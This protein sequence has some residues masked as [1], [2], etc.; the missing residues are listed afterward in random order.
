MK[1]DFENKWV[2]EKELLAV[3][4]SN[5]QGSEL[6]PIDLRGI[7][8]GSQKKRNILENFNFSYVDFSF[9]DFTECNF[10]NLTFSNCKFSNVNFSDLRQ[11]NC[12]YD[13]CIFEKSNFNNA[14]LGVNSNFS[15]CTFIQTTLKGKYFNF[16]QNNLF[17]Q[18]NFIDCDINS[19]WILSVTFKE[20]IFASKFS[21][22]RFS[23]TKE[24]ALSNKTE[25]KNYPATF[26][27]CNFEKSTFKDLEIMDGSI[28]EKTILPNQKSERF[29][30][31]R[32]Y[33]PRSEK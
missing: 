15:N 2:N 6:K 10:T 18:C 3:I 30:N 24:T 31:D 26:I 1:S 27:D 22:I 20:C 11:W 12:K 33:Y 5:Q 9:A 21:D 7:P 8:F 29:N 17:Q 13:N 28:I 4:K 25:G 23:G 32:I 16:G 19:T 14:T